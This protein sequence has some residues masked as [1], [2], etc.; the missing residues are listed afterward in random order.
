MRLITICLILIFIS[1]AQKVQDNVRSLDSTQLMCG[2]VQFANACGPQI[3]SL[4]ALG[5]ALYHHMTFEE[6]RDNFQQAIDIDPDCMWGYWGKA[7]TYVHP[8]WPDVPSQENLNDGLNLTRLSMRRASTPREELFSKALYAYYNDATN[9]TESERLKSYEKAWEVAFE[10]LPGDLEARAFYVLAHLATV[11]PADKSYAKQLRG[12]ELAQSILDEIP[13]HPA[14][15]HYVIH[16]YDYPVLADKAL[17]IARNY[18]KIAPAIPH[19]LHMPTH[20]FTR[21]GLWDESIDW[22]ILSAEAALKYPVKGAVTLHYFHALD[23]QVYA[24]LQKAQDDEAIAVM[25]QMFNLSPPWQFTFPTAYALAAIPARIALESKQWSDAAKLESRRPAHV[26][27]DRFPEFEA[28]HEF[29]RGL[30]LAR[31]GKTTEAMLIVDHMTALQSKVANTSRNAYWGNQI[32]IQKNVVVAWV[33]YALGN[34]DEA[35]RLMELAAD[36][37]SATSKNPVTPGEVLPARELLGDLYAELGQHDMAVKNYDL[38]LERSPNRLNSLMGAAK[39][40]HA[41]GDEESAQKYVLKLKELT[42]DATSSRGSADAMLI[43]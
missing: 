21:L 26:D 41:A 18:G 12:G 7:L 6:A 11:D 3:D 36:M 40:A 32:E 16:S 30:G 1:C 39:S 22:N 38:A 33:R 10:K 43:L 8:I 15:F 14:G 23:Y 28:M 20:I 17:E 13:D 35:V 27:W 29:A 4:L 2:T 34:I 42:K 9:K 31:L 5:I 19:A 25:H 37:E 24:H